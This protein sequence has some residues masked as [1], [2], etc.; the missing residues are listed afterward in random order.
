VPGTD[1]AMKDLPEAL[2]NA[3]GYS[4]ESMN[5]DAKYTSAGA[6]FHFARQP[7]GRWYFTGFE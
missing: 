2:S 6:T 7:G 5:D 1:I 3:G 4:G